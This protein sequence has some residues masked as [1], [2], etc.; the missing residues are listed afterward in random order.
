MQVITAQT[1]DPAFLES[2]EK[3]R[4]HSPV[5]EDFRHRERIL[6][7]ATRFKPSIHPFS[8][9][10]HKRKSAF[11][12]RALPF[13]KKIAPVDFRARIGASVISTESARN[14]DKDGLGVAQVERIF[15]T[16]HKKHFAE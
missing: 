6:E 7:A 15:P 16:R 4:I 2:P 1:R 8:L 5:I 12:S 3:L 9:P 13:V 14:S 11:S 10:F